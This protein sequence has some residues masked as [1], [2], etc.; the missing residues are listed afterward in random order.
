MTGPTC[1]IKN[2]FVVILIFLKFKLHTY[3][4]IQAHTL[5]QQT[6]FVLILNHMQQNSVNIIHFCQTSFL[7]T[8]CNCLRFV[9]GLTQGVQPNKFLTR[10]F[11]LTRTKAMVVDTVTVCMLASKLMK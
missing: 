6:N 11:K 2:T 3:K 5:R 7:L 9:S 8:N 4:N 10:I 1:N